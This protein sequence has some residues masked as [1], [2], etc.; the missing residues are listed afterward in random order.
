MLLQVKQ[1]G[2]RQEEA[3]GLADLGICFGDILPAVRE[4]YPNQKIAIVIR[5]VRAPSVILSQARGG[6]YSRIQTLMLIK[7]GGFSMYAP[8]DALL[9]NFLKIRKK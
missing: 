5:T 1:R 2:K 4:K 3:G 9:R 7:Y 6:S 8:N